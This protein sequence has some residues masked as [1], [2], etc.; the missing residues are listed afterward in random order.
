MILKADNLSVSFNV[1]GVS[2]QAIE[3]ISF[4]V[5][6]GKRYKLSVRASPVST[7]ASIRL[8]VG[9]NWIY[10]RGEQINE[11]LDFTFVA[12]HNS[13]TVDIFNT[14]PGKGLKSVIREIKVIKISAQE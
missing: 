12:N 2:Y 4:T 14:S 6:K 8:G 9:G 11:Q 7:S 5:E 13:L 3:K 1:K 10:K